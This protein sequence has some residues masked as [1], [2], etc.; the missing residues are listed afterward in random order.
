V[1][2]KTKKTRMYS[3][4]SLLLPTSVIKKEKKAINYNI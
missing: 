3:I 4:L 2:R 1:G